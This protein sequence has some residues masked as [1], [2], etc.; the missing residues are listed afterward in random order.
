MKTAVFFVFLSFALVLCLRDEHELGARSL[1]QCEETNEALRNLL[2]NGEKV[3]LPWG[4]QS[5]VSEKCQTVM[6]LERSGN[7]STGIR[8]DFRESC[9]VE[10]DSN[11][12]VTVKSKAEEPAPGSER[13]ATL[14][15]FQAAFLIQDDSINTYMIL[16]P[17]QAHWFFT[18]QLGGCDMFVAKAGSDRH[19]LII[20]HSNLNKVGNNKKQNL[21]LKGTAVDEMLQY[22][23]GYKLIARVYQEPP[24][25]E[26]KQQVDAYFR[27]YT[28]SHPGIA[29][30]SY[31]NHAK[32]EMFHFFGHYNEDQYWIFTLKGGD[33]KVFGQIPIL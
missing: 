19:T 25:G 24:P 2:Q 5:L 20:V 6:A 32:P 17:V 21:E 18:R 26:V 11:L 9:Y 8:Y 15:A 33:G 3:R 13:C 30:K 16:N 1:A 12:V 29:V 4:R 22:H 27:G 23:P 14:S 7:K 28:A 10:G 31:Y